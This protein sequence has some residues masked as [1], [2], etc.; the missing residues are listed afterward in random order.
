MVPRRWLATLAT[1]A[2]LTAPAAA[3]DRV[4]RRAA[5]DELGRGTA[6]FRAGDIVA[7]TQHWSEAVRV[8]RQIGAA[9]IEAQALS[10]RGEAYRIEGYFRDAGSDLQ[11]AL[12]RAQQSGDQALIAATSGA[13]GNLAFMSHRSAVAE[14]LLK[15]SRDLAARLRDPEIVAAS[16]NDLG[17]LYAVTKRPSE[18]ASAYG[19][20]I[21]NAETARDETLAAT[22]E[23]NAARLALGQGDWARAAQ[24]LSQ[25]VDRLDRSPPCYSRGM[26]LIS[27]GS[28]VL[29]RPGNLSPDA[30]AIAYRAFRLAA[31]TADSLH[32]ATLSSRVSPS[33][34]RWPHGSFQSRR[35]R[36]QPL[37]LKP[38]CR[39]CWQ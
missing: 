35:N 15:R 28:A 37:R 33:G 34:V 20:A 12:A 23:I 21:R 26:A 6:A 4:E 16:E 38:T 27:A 18:A 9:D 17:N 13:L 2:L 19:E 32:N 8:C 5:L 11:T 3:Q 24:L 31:Q 29:D 22:A 36:G 30:Q 39:R 10:R 7:A 25:A 1:L 14:P